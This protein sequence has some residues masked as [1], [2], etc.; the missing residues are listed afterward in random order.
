M[1]T[2]SSMLHI[3][4]DDETKAKATEALASMGMSV[5]DAVRL[6]LHRVVVD[7][8]FPLELKV[9]NQE[10]LQAISEADDLIKSRQAH[11]STAKELFDDIEKSST[12]KRASL[13]HASDYTKSFPELIV[14]VRTGTHSD[15]F[16]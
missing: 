3:R 9:P 12:A 2:Q 6:F 8:A 5:S 13:P 16:K 14:F 15:L 4:I 11:F 1:A 10:T 7:Q